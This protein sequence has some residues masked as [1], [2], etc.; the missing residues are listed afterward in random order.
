MEEKTVI[1][2]RETFL[3]GMPIANYLEP[4]HLYV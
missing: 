2:L 4:G 1:Q 3:R